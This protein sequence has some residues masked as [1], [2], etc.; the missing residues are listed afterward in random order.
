MEV[1][2]GKPVEMP[3]S[4][5]NNLLF[6]AEHASSRKRKPKRHRPNQKPSCDP[7][8][9]FANGVRPVDARWRIAACRA[10]CRKYPRRGDD[11]WSKKAFLFLKGFHACRDDY[12]YVQLWWKMPDIWEAY[13]F[14]ITADKMARGTLEG[15]LLAGQSIEE[16]ATACNLPSEAVA[17]YHALFFDVKDKLEARSYILN[18]AIGVLPC[19]ELTE[20][21][22][23]VILK[24]A[25]YL[26]GPVFLEWVLRY[27]RAELKVP[28]QLAGLTREQLD[29]L[30]DLLTVRAL[31]LTWILPPEQMVRVQLLQKLLDQLKSLLDAWP[32]GDAGSQQPGHVVLALQPA[33]C[34]AWWA[35][36][37]QAADAANTGRGLPGLEDTEVA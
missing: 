17:A 21:D 7:E 37:L 4:K 19:D 18:H 1:E 34:E 14:Q 30:H 11:L 36:W 20:E 3:S 31:I 10:Q 33:D 15:R 25:G 6:E 24:R 27:Y 9:F 13:R 35:L 8:L 23:D 12:D 5:S 28:S 2:K 16:V 26:K 29:D 22:V 32:S